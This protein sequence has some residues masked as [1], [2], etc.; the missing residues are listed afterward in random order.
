MRLYKAKITIYKLFRCYLQCPTNFPP[1]W[2][3]LTSNHFAVF[4]N[5]EMRPNSLISSHLKI[6]HSSSLFVF[7][8][9]PYSLSTS[10]KSFK[11]EKANLSNF[12]EHSSQYLCK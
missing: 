4:L 6:T 8:I 7:C 10:N 1:F 12:L 5:L 11:V 2:D 9:F 3:V